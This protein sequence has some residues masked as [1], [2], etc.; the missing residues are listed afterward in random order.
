MVGRKRQIMVSKTV[1]DSSA[2]FAP[3]ILERGSF[4]IGPNE[5]WVKDMHYVE[6]NEGKFYL[7]GNKNLPAG[8]IVGG[9]AD[10]S[11][12]PSLCLLAIQNAVKVEK[13]LPGLTHHL[14][15]N[16][17]Y[18]SR[19]YRAALEALGMICS[20]SRRGQCR[21]NAPAKPLFE[22]LKEKLLPDGH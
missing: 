17:L 13:S 1:C 22:R 20:M 14:D 6:T 21:N 7:A 11:I 10:D 9:V 3:S 15:R 2:S 12:E 18:T 19:A 4:R 8:R 5:I 16:T